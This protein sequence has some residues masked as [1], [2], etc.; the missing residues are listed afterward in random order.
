MDA[1][2]SKWLLILAAFVALGCSKSEPVYVSGADWTP[3][4]SVSL[5]VATLANEATPDVVPDNSP[6]PH[7]DVDKC[8]CK[9]TGVLTHGDGHTTPCPY[10]AK[11]VA[12]KPC[13]CD[14]KN[15]YC[16]CKNKYGV[17]HCNSNK[18]TEVPRRRWPFLEFLF[19]PK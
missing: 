11:S 2:N 5:G 7:P 1:R 10:H 3:T 12:R 6:E 4:I 19:G 14:T 18:K 17:C 15:T 16:N 8:A 13:K 9:G